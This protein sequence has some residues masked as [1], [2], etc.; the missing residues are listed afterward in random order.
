MECMYFLLWAVCKNFEKCWPKRM[1]EFIFED[2]YGL[3]EERIYW[4]KFLLCGDEAKLFT[5]TQPNCKCHWCSVMVLHGARS[6]AAPEW[7]DY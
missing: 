7:S 1:L 6:I 3:A 2:S 5:I 4:F